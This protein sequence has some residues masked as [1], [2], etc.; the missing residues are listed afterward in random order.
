M[1]TERKE[2]PKMPNS[3]TRQDVIRSSDFNFL[4]VLG[5]G[6]FGKVNMKVF[7]FLTASDAML[8]K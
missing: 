8:W 4:T 5:K 6:S 3:T 2:P 1:K 7:Y